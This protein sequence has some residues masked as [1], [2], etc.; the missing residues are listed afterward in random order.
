[1]TAAMPQPDHPATPAERI[2]DLQELLRTAPDLAP[3]LEGLIEALRTE[4]A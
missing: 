1:M 3:L 4:D 2:A